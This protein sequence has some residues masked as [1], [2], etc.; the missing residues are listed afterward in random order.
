M[1]FDLLLALERIVVHSTFSQSVKVFILLY[2][3]F[4]N[5]PLN[6]LGEIPACQS[7]GLSVLFVYPKFFFRW[8]SLYYDELVHAII[9][10]TF[11]IYVLRTFSLLSKIYVIVYTYK[12]LGSYCLQS[13]FFCKVKLLKLWVL[14]KSFITIKLCFETKKNSVRQLTV[15]EGKHYHG[16]FKVCK[17]TN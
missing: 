7:S 6:S 15:T 10:S 5:M 16:N 11:I 9:Q 1:S 13:L 4:L 2:C 17:S 12:I 8:I 3:P 14:I